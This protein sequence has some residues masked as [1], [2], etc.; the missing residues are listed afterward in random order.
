MEKYPIHARYWII[1]AFMY[2]IDVRIRQNINDIYNKI[3]EAEASG[4]A[5]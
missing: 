5:F 1:I 2:I 3:P 4:I